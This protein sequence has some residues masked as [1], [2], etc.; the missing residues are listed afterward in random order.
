MAVLGAF[1]SLK[2]S[3]EGVQVAIVR[4]RWWTRL[5]CQADIEAS[6]MSSSR[7]SSLLVTAWQESSSRFSESAARAVQF[8]PMW[9]VKTSLHALRHGQV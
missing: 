8:L 3:R 5:D 4:D 9:Q 7:L 1:Y 2:S 6:R